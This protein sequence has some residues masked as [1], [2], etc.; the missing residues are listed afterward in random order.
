[1]FIL[2]K[3]TTSLLTALLLLSYIAPLQ[4]QV[5]SE[6]E[7]IPP[8]TQETQN[9]VKSMPDIQTE[10]SA[11]AQEIQPMHQAQTQ[12]QPL[13]ARIATAPRGT[14]FEVKI[15]STIN[16]MSSRVGDTFSA[17]IAEP[18]VIDS[19]TLIPAGSELIGQV[20]FVE[21]AGRIGKNALM[22]IRFTSIRLP[23]G[24]RMPINA[25]ITT[26]DAS[27]VLKGGKKSNIVLRTAK[28]TVG[29]TA[30]GA[31][32]GVGTGAILG[33]VGVGSAA[34]MGTAIGGIAGLGYALYH[35]GKDIVL[36]SG[37]QLGVTL[38]QPLT[39]SN[40]KTSDY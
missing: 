39:V 4:A 5:T 9:Y 3:A 6:Y 22:D 29:T 30:V 27:G 11:P 19:K 17:E 21:S 18:L 2:R 33:G 1:M 26:T 16:S 8:V 20:T 35:K 25:K 12:M 28:T 7:V 36:P 31:I 38:E 14:T 23:D 32:G 15:N 40:S 37:T 10:Y 34:I 24:E 13:Q